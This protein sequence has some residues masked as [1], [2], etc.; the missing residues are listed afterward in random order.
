[1]KEKGGE[2]GFPPS[3]AANFR[4]FPRQTRSFLGG[5]VWYSLL[6]LYRKEEP[7]RIKTKAFRSLFPPFFSFTSLLHRLI[8]PLLLEGSKSRTTETVV[9]GKPLRSEEAAIPALFFVVFT[10][11]SFFSLPYHLVHSI[12]ADRAP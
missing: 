2:S 5:R 4:L 11:F 9:S 1:M 8:R 7:Q 10:S 12:S 3:F 6:E